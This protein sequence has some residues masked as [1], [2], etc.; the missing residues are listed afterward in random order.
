MNTVVDI[1]TSFIPSGTVRLALKL[2]LLL[3]R[4]FDKKET[5]QWIY[6]RLPDEFQ[7]GIGRFEK[8]VKAGD[9]FMKEVWEYKHAPKEQ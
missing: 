7:K 9:A 5:L 1:L 4:A 3:S 8:L 2:V 6:D